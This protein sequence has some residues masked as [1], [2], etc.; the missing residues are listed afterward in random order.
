MTD[1]NSRQIILTVVLLGILGMLGPIGNDIFIPAIPKIAGGLNTTTSLVSISISAIFLGSAIG[2]LLHGPL[3]DQLGRKPVILWVL[4]I[5]SLAATAAAFSSNVETLII[6]RFF[7]GIAQSGGRVLSATVA[8]DLFD[9]ERLGK[10]MSDVMFITSV[11]PVVAPII[12]G[13]TAK[14]LPWQSSLVF[15]AIFAGLVFILFSTMFRESIASERLDTLRLA[16]LC[17][18]IAVTTTN[19]TFQMHSLCG[20]FMLAGF[21]VFLSV[22]ANILIESYGVPPETYGFM[23]AAISGCYLAGTFIGGRLVTRLGLG[24]MVG[25]GILIALIGSGLMLV[26][27][28][29]TLRTPIALIIPMGIYT[30]GLGFVNPNTIA[31]ALQP[32]REIAGSASSM[33]NFIRGIMGAG[34]SFVMSFFRHDDA[35]VMASTMFLLG[36]AAAIVYRFGIQKNSVK[37]EG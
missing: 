34:V 23:F 18:N 22:S 25:W 27:A 15:M 30:F 17:R 12:G 24:R 19:H 10:M 4:G 11:A 26:M 5:Y 3:A 33:T 35:L 21:V 31:G 14:Y 2:T 32:F 6:C 1:L 8:R 13:Y 7:Q 29:M 36:C 16:D 37:S 9:K 28:G 20:G